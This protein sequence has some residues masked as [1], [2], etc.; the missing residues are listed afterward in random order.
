MLRKIC[1]VIRC[2]VFQGDTTYAYAL[3]N[4]E[5]NK[6]GKKYLIVSACLGL[7]HEFAS[8]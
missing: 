1:L 4:S 6:L 7:T 8:T 3:F 2:I 5:S